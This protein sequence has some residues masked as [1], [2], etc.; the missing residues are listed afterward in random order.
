[1]PSS[2]VGSNRAPWPPFIISADASRQRRCSSPARFMGKT[3]PK[4]QPVCVRQSARSDGNRSRNCMIGSS[5][6]RRPSSTRPMSA[7][8]RQRTSYRYSR[9]SMRSRTSHCA[10][11]FELAQPAA[12]ETPQSSS[13]TARRRPG[14]AFSATRIQEAPSG[15]SSGSVIILFASADRAGLR[16]GGD[17]RRRKSEFRENGRRIFADPRRHARRGFSFARDTDRA[18]ERAQQGV[19]FEGS[20]Q[21]VRFNL[22][23]IEMILRLG[24]GAYR[25]VRG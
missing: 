8:L 13:T 14:H 21:F 20:Q 25:D 17:L 23:A 18:V 7:R 15:V 6:R 24:D 10:R 11:R 1:M 5:R 4:C 2:M 19:V 3:F 22:G 9:L 12:T 16:H